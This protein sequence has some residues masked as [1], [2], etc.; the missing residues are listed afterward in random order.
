M[1]SQLLI[2]CCQP[3]GV[4]VGGRLPLLDGLELGVF[5]LRLGGV[6]LPGFR[7]GL[8]ELWAFSVEVTSL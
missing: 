2:A 4:G 1:S 3:T 7:D 5:R 8:P 6:D